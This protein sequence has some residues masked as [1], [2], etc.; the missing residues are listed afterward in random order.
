MSSDEEDKGD[1]EERD[2]D[3]HHHKNREV[4]QVKKFV[5]FS[6]YKARLCPYSWVKIRVKGEKALKNEEN[7]NKN[8]S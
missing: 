6:T 4:N 8:K 2:V 1:D 7:N 5:S 3:D